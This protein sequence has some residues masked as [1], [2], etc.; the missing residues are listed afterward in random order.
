VDWLIVT[1][2]LYQR[3]FSR[4]ALLAFRNWPVLFTSFVYGALVQL[5]AFL[6]AP[7][8]IFAGIL[9][10]LVFAACASSFLFL[11]E[12]MVRTGRVS[13]ADFQRSFGVYLWD[14]VTLSF[15][16]WLASMLLVPAILQLPQG[17]VILSC[18]LLAAFV[19]FN[20]VPELIY[21]GRAPVLSLFGESY[22]FIANNWIE[23]LPANLVAAA[24]LWLVASLPADGVGAVLSLFLTPLLIYF[25]MVMRGLLFL[26]LSSTSRR[27]RLF[28]YRAGS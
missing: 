10:S 28:R 16:V 22:Q 6:S 4:A 24:L 3:V 9:N 14:F 12:T 20:A 2:N 21:L 13:W 15:L 1:W 18:V 17:M 5:T 26:E 11:I 8:G 19:F 7:L 23:W 27:G 25:A